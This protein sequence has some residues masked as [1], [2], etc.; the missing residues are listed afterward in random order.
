MKT[1]G[2]VLKKKLK[3]LMVAK[4]FNIEKIKKKLGSN[5]TMIYH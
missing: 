1:F 5:L 3:T 2:R 4:K